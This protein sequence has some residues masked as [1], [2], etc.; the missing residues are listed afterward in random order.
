MTVI[1]DL[2][3]DLIHRYG[4]VGRED[5]KRIYQEE[6]DVFVIDRNIRM[7]YENIISIY[8][9]VRRFMEFVFSRNIKK[10]MKKRMINKK[11]EVI[12]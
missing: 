9:Y 12:A 8:E 2:R 1:S 5:K 11:N 4:M 6:L 7:T 10:G 3:N